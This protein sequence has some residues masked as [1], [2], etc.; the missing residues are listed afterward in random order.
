MHDMKKLIF[1]VIIFAFG[2]AAATDAQ[3]V[4]TLFTKQLPE[5][6]GSVNSRDI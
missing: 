2:F 6:P 4:N 1:S 5:A 3:Q